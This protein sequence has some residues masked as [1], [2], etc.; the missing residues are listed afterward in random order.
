VP[1]VDPEGC[2]D[3]AFPVA[4]DEDR[5]VFGLVPVAPRVV[6]PREPAAGHRRD[7]RNALRLPSE[8]AVDG[9]QIFA[10]AATGEAAE[11]G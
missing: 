7:D 10:S 11:V 1:G 9:Q 6:D 3:S 2:D 8:R 5:D 4:P